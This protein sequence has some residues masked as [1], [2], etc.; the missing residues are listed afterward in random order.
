VQLESLTEGFFA[1]KLHFASVSDLFLERSTDYGFLLGQGTETPVQIGW[2]HWALAA[3]ALPAG[4]LLW[5]SGGRTGATAVAVLASGFAIG[6]FM[7]ISA[8]KGIWDAFGPLAY[9][10][11]P[12]RYLGLVSL[13][14]AGLA[15]A[16]LAV[17]RDRPVA[18]RLA[19]TAVLLGVLIGTGRPFFHSELR[20][21]VSDDDVLFGERFAYLRGGSI[22]D[23]LPNAV[24]Q[25]P[26]PRAAR[27]Q[28]VEGA[29]EVVSARSGSDW[30]TLEIEA[31]EPVRVEASLFDFPEWR[32]RID[33]EEV[34]HGASTPHGLVTFSVPR[35]RHEVQLNLESTAVRKAGNYVSLLSW[36]ALAVSVP[37][38]LLAPKVRSWRGAGG[39][40]TTSLSS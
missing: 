30:L 22:A 24:T 3:L 20:F 19:L 35:G 4:A 6:T 28:V 7:A 17:L 27:A 2:F 13:S 33:G 18:V 8:S 10:Q 1:Y 36:L 40:A 15:G 29:G 31:A 34:E 32:V 16:W 25:V 5:R 39:M 37:A 14:A 38:L 26:E 9:L 11:F 23:Y 21:D 12:W